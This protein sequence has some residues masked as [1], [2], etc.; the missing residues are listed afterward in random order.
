VD[1]L[2]AVSVIN[3]ASPEGA[4]ILRAGPGYQMPKGVSCAEKAVLEGGQ[5]RQEM[6]I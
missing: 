3:V 2:L 5:M 6:R 4:D 1:S